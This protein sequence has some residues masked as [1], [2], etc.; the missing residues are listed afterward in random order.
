M[1]ILILGLG[2]SFRGDDGIGPAVIAALQ[3]YAVPAGGEDAAAALPPGVELVDGGT[4]G[5]ETALLLEGYQRVIIVDAANLGQAPGEWIRF[6]PMDVELGPADLRGTLHSAGLPEAL[7][8][9]DALEILPSEIVIFGVQPYETGW[10][11]G[12]SPPVRAA[13]PALCEAIVAEVTAW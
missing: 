12:L 1:T 3:A 9:A 6:T 7:A 13:I 8:L 2:N 5:M 11:P 4:P 10:T